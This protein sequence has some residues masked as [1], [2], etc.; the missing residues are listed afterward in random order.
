MGSIAAMAPVAV[1][2]GAP[3]AW[4]S[5]HRADDPSPRA[6]VLAAADV[7]RP[8]LTPEAGPRQRGAVAAMDLAGHMDLAE[9]YPPS[10]G[11]TIIL[12]RRRDGR[13]GRVIWELDLDR[14]HPPAGVDVAEWKR[15]IG[16]D[17]RDFYDQTEPTLVRPAPDLDGDGTRD[18]V[19]A[20]IRPPRS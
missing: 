13:S 7:G 16:S 15:A 12:A 3:I 14:A 11:E 5:W 8:L 19:W 4:K 20:G 10:R 17:W 2:A 18:L 6:E 9:V 1:V